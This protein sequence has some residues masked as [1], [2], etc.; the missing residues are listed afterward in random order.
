VFKKI[1]IANRGDNAAGAAAQADIA[2]AKSAAA[3]SR[4]V[5]STRGD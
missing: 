2:P 4:R 3:K 5:R 1:L